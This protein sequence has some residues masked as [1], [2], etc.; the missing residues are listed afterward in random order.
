MNKSEIYKCLDV[1]FLIIFT[2]INIKI[3]NIFLKEVKI[4]F[5]WIYLHSDEINLL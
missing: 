5:E 4:L 1:I 2:I 3:I